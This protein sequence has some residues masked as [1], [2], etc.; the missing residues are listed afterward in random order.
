MNSLVCGLLVRENFFHR[1]NCWLVASISRVKY[2]AEFQRKIFCPPLV[3]R[4]G[5]DLVRHHRRKYEESWHTGVITAY[6]NVC[7]SVGKNSVCSWI[8]SSGVFRLT[9][10][11]ISH[12]KFSNLGRDSTFLAVK[13]TSNEHKYNHEA[14]ARSEVPSNR[15]VTSNHFIAFQPLLIYLIT[16]SHN[17]QRLPQRITLP[18]LVQVRQPRFEKMTT[19]PREKF[20]RWWRK[21]CWGLE[22][23]AS[24]CKQRSGCS[25]LIRGFIANFNRE[26]ARD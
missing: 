19:Q 6:E 8:L 10:L 1:H 16:V 4:W 25:N 24:F 14:H 12:V 20:Q 23:T 9:M 26:N 13:T 2:A 21:M 18:W 3:T 7:F 11:F 5:K 17:I 15:R 22:R